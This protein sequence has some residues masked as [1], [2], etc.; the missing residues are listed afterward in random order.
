[1]HAEFHNGADITTA[2]E[3]YCK[4]RNPQG[5]EAEKLTRLTAGW[6]R[7]TPEERV[8]LLEYLGPYLITTSH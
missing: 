4:N 7:L 3:A 5:E 1:M 8:V 6:Y 2:Y